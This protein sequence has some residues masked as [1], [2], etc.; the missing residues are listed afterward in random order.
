MPKRVVWKPS[1][2]CQWC[3]ASGVSAAVRLYQNEDEDGL[4]QLCLPCSW[5]LPQFAQHDGSGA[6]A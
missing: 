3:G 1:L 2:T 6:H 4:L 5:K